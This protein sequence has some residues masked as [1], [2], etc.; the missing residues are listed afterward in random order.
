MSKPNVNVVATG[1]HRRADGIYGIKVLLANVP[2]A[3]QVTEPN[4]KYVIRWN[5]DLGGETVEMPENCILQFEGGSLSNGTIVGD[6]TQINADKTAIFNTINI[7]GDWD[8]PYITSDWFSDAHEDNVSRQLF[9]LTNDFVANVVVFEEGTF[10]VSVSTNREAVYMPKSN[11]KVIILG[12]IILAPN[13]FNYYFIFDINAK[14]NIEVTGGGSI[15]GDYSGTI[16][17]PGHSGNFGHGFGVR[18]TNGSERISVCDIIISNCSGDSIYVGGL[19][20]YTDG[21][22]DTPPSIGVRI[23]G[24]TMYDSARQAISV[25]NATSVIIEGCTMHDIRSVSPGAGID[26][27]PN[28]GNRVDNVSITNNNIYNC[29]YGVTTNHA[30]DTSVAVFNVTITSNRMHGIKGGISLQEVE[31]IV[32]HSNYITSDGDFTIKGRSLL[33]NASIM[34]NN[35]VNTRQEFTDDEKSE[36]SV[37]AAIIVMSSKGVTIA[38]NI[39]TSVAIPACIL[40]ST[41]PIILQCNKI[42]A[43]YVFH[44]KWNLSAIS[45]DNNNITGYCEMNLTTVCSLR[46]NIFNP[47]STINDINGSPLPVTMNKV[48]IKGDSFTFENNVVY[49]P[50]ETGLQASTSSNRVINNTF[51]ISVEGAYQ[52]DIRII[53]LRSARFENNNVTISKVNESVDPS[54]VSIV[55]ALGK[56]AYVGNTVINAT[57][58]VINECLGANSSD[59]IGTMIEIG[60]NNVSGDFNRIYSTSKSLCR[61]LFSDKPNIGNNSLMYQMS[62]SLT[63]DDSGVEFYN[64]TLQKSV[65]WNGS[66]WKS[67]NTAD[68]DATVSGI[69]SDRPTAHNHNIPIG[70]AYFCYY[71]TGNDT[72][73]KYGKPIFFAGWEYPDQ[74]NQEERVDIWV[75]AQGQRFI[76]E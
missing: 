67:A 1:G 62:E 20:H 25:T 50:F 30:E 60:F 32:I 15:I 55:S 63:E 68:P 11:T 19:G 13:N 17:A 49:V 75:D 71:K 34:S 44:P 12:N 16:D 43:P 5:F 39:V 45:I 7:D 41:N 53:F 33:N 61:F 48:L 51:N 10:N 56:G 6:G 29:F 31:S 8:C 73:S 4:M 37:V 9:Q 2:F 57:G 69:F 40:V 64:T 76:E 26:L 35:I 47:A 24:V 46:S 66:S 70:Y 18:I 74:E 58:N 59:V 27:E 22:E 36:K 28:P 72:Y 14:T 23:M 3:V 52:K 54:T 42:S 38:S 65:W 21:V